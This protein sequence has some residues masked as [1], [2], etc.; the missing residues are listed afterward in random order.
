MFDHMI[1]RNTEQRRK[2][3]MER[4]SAQASVRGRRLKRGS[5]DELSDATTGEVLYVE[6]DY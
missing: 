1:R 4:R 5:G 2:T 3:I 6:V